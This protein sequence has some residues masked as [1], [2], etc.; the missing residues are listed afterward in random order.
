MSTDVRTVRGRGVLAA[1]GGVAGFGVAGWV[2]RRY[3]LD[4]AA[5]QQRLAAVDWAVM[6]TR[7][8]PVE[9]AEHGAGEP[10]LVSHD[11][12]HGCDGGLLSLRGLIPDRRVTAPSRFGYLGSPL[13]AGATPADQADAYGE[14]LDGLGI[15]EVDVIGI[16]DG[17]TS[18]LQF[19]LRHPERSL[20]PGRVM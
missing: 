20:L 11:I 8:G 16:S 6:Q 17:V 15:T 3:R 2:V 10:V 7:F 13:P 4:L 19:A 5:A 18:A 14:L 9:Y 1:G 12:L